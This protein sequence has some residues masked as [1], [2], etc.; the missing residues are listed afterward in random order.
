LAGETLLMDMNN[1]P[2]RY[3]NLTIEELEIIGYFARGQKYSF[4]SKNLK[5]EF[6][7]TSIRLSDRQGKLLDK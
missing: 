4:S 3:P 7:E 2:G 5:L 1:I 6:S